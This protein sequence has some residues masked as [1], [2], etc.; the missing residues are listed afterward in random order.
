[1]S[2][3]LDSRSSY[4]LTK[5]SD[6]SVQPLPNIV[7]RVIP[8]SLARLKRL[9]WNVMLALQISSSSSVSTL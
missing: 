6:F 1:M 5:E 2:L 3:F 7:S 4:S 8:R 9:D